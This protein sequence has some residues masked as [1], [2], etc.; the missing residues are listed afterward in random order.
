MRRQ[1]RGQNA[2]ILSEDDGR[3]LTVKRLTSLLSINRVFV[4]LLYTTRTS[5]MYTVKGRDGDKENLLA[6]PVVERQLRPNR[7]EDRF[8]TAM[9]VPRFG[10]LDFQHEE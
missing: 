9:S 6:P 7:S 1:G 2:P 10:S 3:I 8:G 5:M 4:G